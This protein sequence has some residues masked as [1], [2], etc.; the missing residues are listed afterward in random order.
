MGLS[1]PPM[2][3]SHFSLFDIPLRQRTKLLGTV[4]VVEGDNGSRLPAQCSVLTSWL[5]RSRVPALPLPRALS[6]R[7]VTL[8]EDMYTWWLLKSRTGTNYNW[9]QRVAIT[10]TFWAAI[11]LQ[12]R[13][14]VGGPSCGPSRVAC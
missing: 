13:H 3:T 8:T 11:A 10:L 6:S 14:S 12:V 5:L 7:E 2:G 9:L 4:G 1:R